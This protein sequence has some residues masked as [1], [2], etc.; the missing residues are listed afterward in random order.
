METKHTKITIGGLSGTGKGTVA[1]MLAEKL[2][3]QY[4]SVG[5]FVRE[6]IK[7]KGIDILQY[8][9][10]KNKDPEVAEKILD[11]RTKDFGL[12][13]DSF[14]FEGHIAA[15]FIPDAFKILLTCDDEVRINRIVERQNMSYEE[16]KYETLEREKMQIEN[17]KKVYNI[18]DHVNPSHYDLVID[19]TSVLPEEIVEKIINKLR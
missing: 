19:T 8:N 2:G 18:E 9:T 13:N 15:F 3:F 1:K 4:M 6:I 16:S 14:V 10:E 5:N 17:Y 12:K 11:N 7:E